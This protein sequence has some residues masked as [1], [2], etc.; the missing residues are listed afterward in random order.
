VTAGVDD[1]AAA[2]GVERGAE[3]EDGTGYALVIFFEKGD[4]AGVE[5]E[6][7]FLL[8]EGPLEGVFDGAGLRR[9]GIARGEHG[10]EKGITAGR[11]FRPELEGP[12]GFLAEIAAV[13]DDKDG[14]ALGPGL[15][16]GG[17]GGTAAA[18]DEDI[19]L[20]EDG[21]ANGAFRSRW[22][23]GLMIVDFSKKGN[24]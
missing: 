1:A 10:G 20:G 14:R 17:D 7:D 24:R 4:G 22:V 6:G 16:G 15:E 13:A 19:D 2:D 18:D 8:E 5:P 21:D 23:H 3:R 11:A 12:G 9:S